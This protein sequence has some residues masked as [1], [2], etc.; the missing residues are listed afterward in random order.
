MPPEKPVFYA[1]GTRLTAN[2]VDYG[3]GATQFLSWH[4][5]MLDLDCR[6]Q[7]F[8]TGDIACIPDAGDASTYF[9]DAGCTEPLMAVFDPDGCVQVSYATIAGASPTCDNPNPQG[10]PD[11]AAFGGVRAVTTKYVGA[12]VFQKSGPSCVSQAAPPNLTLYETGSVVP[13]STFV[14]ATQA[15]EPRGDKMS[16]G[17]LVGSDGSWQIR[18][19]FSGDSPC[20]LRSVALPSGAVQACLPIFSG[21]IDHTPLFTDAA[22]GMAYGTPVALAKANLCEDPA[23][24][25]DKTV[26]AN[27]CT[28]SEVLLAPGAPTT[29]PAL[30][31]GSP[32]T[33]S[34]YAQGMTTAYAAGAPLDPLATFGEPLA[35]ELGTGRIHAAFYG[36]AL[37]EALASPHAFIDTMTSARCAAVRFDDQTVRCVDAATATPSAF[38]DAACTTPLVVHTPS[39]CSPAPAPTQA[40]VPSAA[41]GCSPI[42]AASGVAKL[43]SYAGPSFKRS[44]AQCVAFVPPAGAQLFGLGAAVDVTAYAAVDLVTH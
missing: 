3:D 10:A 42:R 21:A 13:L 17:V 30:F 44:G 1:D 11:S 5:A 25:L 8:T 27:G 2:V 35:L 12:T 14:Q 34:P 6:F 28:T 31:S 18:R 23:F 15:K 43:D 24:I 19:P 39:T 33:C 37:D 26:D 16:E 7:T 4:D 32:V 20:A 22:C 29:L 38:A 9:A 41:P 36:T 40:L